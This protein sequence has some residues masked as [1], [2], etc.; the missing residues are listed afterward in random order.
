MVAETA[1]L[2]IQLKSAA[3]TKKELD[4]ITKALKDQEA[5]ARKRIDALK[6]EE[7]AI[8]KTSTPNEKRVKEIR[9]EISEQ[10]ASIRVGRE[11][12][13]M[14]RA[15]SAAAAQASTANRA[16]AASTGLAAGAF[17]SLLAPLIAI[18]AAFSAINIIK[19]ADEYRILKG[20][21]AEVTRDFGNFGAALKGIESI[22]TE[23]GAGLQETTEVFQRIAVGARD[24]GKSQDD[25]LQLVRSVEQLGVIGGSSTE[26]LKAGLLQFGQAMSSQIVRAEEFNSLLENLPLVATAI[27]K[28]LGVSVGQLRQ[29]VV[30]GKVLSEDVFKALSGQADDI[31]QRFEALPVSL[32][33]ALNQLDIAFTKFVGAVDDSVGASSAFAKIISDVAGNV[34][35][36]T[37]N[38]NDLLRGFNALTSA[39]SPLISA[40]QDLHNSAGIL[41]RSIIQLFFD[42]ES[43]NQLIE[44][45]PSPVKLLAIGMVALG[46][47]VDRLATGFRLLQINAT[48]SIDAISARLKTGFNLL[49]NAD[50]EIQKINKQAAFKAA[51]EL[52][53]FG[54][55]EGDR[56]KLKG[57][58]LTG[59]GFARGGGDAGRKITLPPAGGGGGRTRKGGAGGAGRDNT[60]QLERQR[61]QEI[62]DKLRETLQDIDLEFEA[63][64]EKLGAFAAEIDKLN[65]EKERSLE[66]DKAL[67]ATAQEVLQLDVKSK[68][69]VKEK[70][71]TLRDLS[72]ALKGNS[73]EL[74]RNANQNDAL[75]D[76]IQKARREAELQ[77]SEIQTQG[78]V[79]RKQLELENFAR[80]VETLYSRGLITVQE[81][82]DTQ[83]DLAE[84]NAQLEK[85]LL[86]QRIYILEQERDALHDNEEGERRRLQINNDILSTKEQ[87]LNL[88]KE[89]KNEIT[90]INT[91]EEQDLREF[92]DRVGG[93]VEGAISDAIVESFDGTG[94]KQAIQNFAKRLRD[95]I[96]R[97]FADAIAERLKKALSNAFQNF[98][99]NLNNISGRSGPGG[100]LAPNG[101][102]TGSLNPGI[103]ALSQSSQV[104]ASSAKTIG[105]TF[106]SFTTT[107]K[108]PSVQGL[109]GGIALAGGLSLAKKGGGFN[110]A[111]GAGLGALGGGLLGAQLGS[112]LLPGIGTAIGAGVGA[113]AGGAAALFGGGGDKKEQERQKRIKKAQD[114]VSELVGGANANDVNDLIARAKALNSF[115]SG[116]GQAFGIKRE[117]LLQL[118]ELIRQ[119]QATI[120][121]VITQTQ[122]DITDLGFENAIEASK[123]DLQRV[124]LERDRALVNLRNETQAQLAQFNDS[125]QA[126]SEILKKEALKRQLILEQFRK[127]EE[128]ANKQ[129]IDNFRTGVQSLESLL[130]RRDD[131]ENA[132][133][134]QRL[135]TA[136][137]K[138]RDDLKVVDAEIARQLQDF[139][140]L[141]TS[142]VSIPQN[143]AGINQ[144]ISA[145]NKAGSNVNNNLE[146][147]INGAQDPNAVSEEVRRALSSFFGKNLGVQVA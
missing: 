7:I 16:L 112:M 85:T 57:S 46:D 61:I 147:I 38:A 21:I 114:R 124:Q 68:E 82:Y 51:G 52:L 33:R 95:I 144:I 17:R 131:I 146:I 13:V 119:R 120:Q 40:F 90:N 8:R 31:Q 92:G 3:K 11:K 79:S 72:Q 56:N 32:D 25:V 113:L 103:G 86:E 1:I 81:Y 101:G 87:I 142:G 6:Q 121:Q 145:L 109:F 141:R 107:L 74:L 88:E 41:I 118:N 63:R 73:N 127:Q 62:E 49:G 123:N 60:A 35:E 34:S 58:I 22:A 42:L 111:A 55:R 20:R 4:A 84:R 143:I 76:S 10:R 139:E 43:V 91:Q 135:R 138:K 19:R 115:K 70:Q 65:L 54:Q 50:Q 5:E 71:K 128:E 14:L 64:I 105:S 110:K 26:A 9:K 132:N 136:E 77:A 133:V 130:Q 122:L 12:V 94:P 45:M 53:N 36:L 102:I 117:G 89:T 83:R 48:A 44:A 29:M 140:K 126:Q 99:Q 47:V 75:A 96:L 100:S 23:T 28:G 67:K 78:T 59:G 37:E 80:S 137:T 30:D 93:Q 27:A 116:G 106:K 129:V 69:A 134:F 66:K 104:L 18:G 15:E 2:D 97:A 98:G 39:L 108:N 24:L 125:Q